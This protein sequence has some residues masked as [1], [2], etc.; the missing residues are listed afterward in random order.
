VFS[1]SSVLLSDTERYRVQ[2]AVD[3]GDDFV[4]STAWRCGEPTDI[5]ED[6]KVDS[7][8]VQVPPGA[9]HLFVS[10]HDQLYYDNSDPDGDYA[11]RITKVTP[12]IHSLTRRSSHTTSLKRRPSR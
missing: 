5:P 11:I 9:T 7:T 1:A 3:A 12:Q 4:T 8:V 2:D 10:G 6:F